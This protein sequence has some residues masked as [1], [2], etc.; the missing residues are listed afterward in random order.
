MLLSVDSLIPRGLGRSYG[1]S[2]SAQTVMQSVHL[3][4][5]IEF[6]KNA[7]T[8]T[9]EAGV[10]IRDILE[11]IVPS[12]WFVPV[13]PGTSYVTIGGAIASD[14][15]GKNHHF[16]GT[17]CQHVVSMRLL[18]GTGEVVTTSP[19][20][21]PDLF[22]ATCA[23]MG[24]TGIILSATLRLI[25]IQSARIER[26]TIKASCL[27]DVC[28]KFEAHA[29]STYSVA[30]IDCMT[31]GKRAGRSILMLG[32]HSGHA[33]DADWRPGKPI[34]MPCDAPAALLNRWSIQSFNA[35]YYAKHR[36]GARDCV[37]IERYFYPLDK[38]SNWNRLY[39]KRGFVQYQFVL[40]KEDGARNMKRLFGKILDSRSGS[41][42][43]VLK[44]LG[45]ENGN[46]LSFP[47]EGCT[48]ALDFRLSAHTRDLLA[49][50]DGLVADMGGRIYLAK[51]ALMTEATF[52]K[53]YPR[54]EAFDAVRERYG[55]TGKFLSDQS[56]RLGLR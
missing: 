11:L 5:F 24:L 27:E 56:R 14:V 48:L 49:E 12:G 3:D 7:G 51:D 40:P 31:R 42:L 41:F 15:H 30:W 9:C 18:L 22:H 54:I 53:S 37:P 17:F 10:S 45:K 35:L 13:T 52:R 43:A 39:G 46:L 1:D 44:Q 29:G 16:A 47:M 2:A 26:T 32:E 34:S 25:P 23:G 33:T 50:L 19:A 38:V 55:A 4:R 8:L 28:E 36:H 20:E 6:D 21:R